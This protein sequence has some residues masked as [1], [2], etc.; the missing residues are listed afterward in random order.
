MSSEMTSKG[1]LAYAKR[2]FVHYFTMTMKAAG[3]RADSDTVGEIE[4]AVEALYDA[5][6]IA[7]TEISYDVEE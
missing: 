1:D 5:A 6:V 3:L 2:I 4:S 7:A